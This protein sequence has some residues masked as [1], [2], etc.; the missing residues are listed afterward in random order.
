MLGT[1]RVPFPSPP[2]ILTPYQL[3]IDLLGTAPECDPQQILSYLFAP[4]SILRLQD[5][6][7]VGFHLSLPE[8]FKDAPDA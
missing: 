7:G 2:P 8:G 6:D 3:H 4:T 1:N 5:P